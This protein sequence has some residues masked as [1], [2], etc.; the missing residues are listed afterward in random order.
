MFP[1]LIA[2]VIAVIGAAII[3]PLLRKYWEREQFKPAVFLRRAGANFAFLTAAAI[4]FFLLG[5]AVLAYSIF[6]N[7]FSSSGCINC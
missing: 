5:F 2:L 4:I 7:L 1:S 3:V 6:S